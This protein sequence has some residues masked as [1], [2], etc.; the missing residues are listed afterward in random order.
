MG[1]R[2]VTGLTKPARNPRL[3]PA[4]EEPEGG[5]S[6][7]VEASGQGRGRREEKGERSAPHPQLL[8][9]LVLVHRES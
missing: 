8:A 3:A 4:M 2:H 7:S 1:N 6:L 9:E 5:A